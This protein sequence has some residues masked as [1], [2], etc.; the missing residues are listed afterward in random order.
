MIE[1]TSPRRAL[2]RGPHHAYGGGVSDFEDLV[3]QYERYLAR[4]EPASVAA[5]RSRLELWL[6]VGLPE[7]KVRIVLNRPIPLE[8]M[9]RI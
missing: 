7:L 4:A 8:D 9:P 1:E 5:A 3:I 6:R 2:T